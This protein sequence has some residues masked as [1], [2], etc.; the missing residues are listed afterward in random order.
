MN[1][2][3][4][5]SSKYGS[6]NSGIGLSEWQRRAQK[7]AIGSVSGYSADRSDIESPPAS[8]SSSSSNRGS[9]SKDLATNN[10]K[11]I[12]ARQVEFMAK[13]RKTEENNF[14]AF[15]V[16][17]DLAR[18]GVYSL[19]AMRSRALPRGAVNMSSVK[20]ILVSDKSP[21]P[22]DLQNTDVAK[23]ES[24]SFDYDA[25]SELFKA[26][27]YFYTSN[28]TIPTPSEEAANGL[29][30]S[31]SSSRTNS[32]SEEEE[33][34]ANATSRK[35]ETEGPSTL[36][37]ASSNAYYKHI[38]KSLNCTNTLTLENALF[39]DNPRLIVDSHPCLT[40][41]HGNAA[42]SQLTGL[43]SDKVIGKSIQNIFD[44]SF[45]ADS[46]SVLTRTDAGVFSKPA[47]LK[48]R[49]EDK[50]LEDSANNVQGGAEPAIQDEDEN[51]SNQEVSSFAFTASPIMTNSRIS[52][53]VIDLSRSHTDY[54]YNKATGTSDAVQL[55]AQPL[56]AIG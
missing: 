20:L 46:D 45:M 5:A 22:G 56:N 4:K 54:S 10:L 26:A 36:S 40:I 49:L 9:N 25:Y 14:Q 16:K 13:K 41:I 37:S 15:N 35:V 2:E 29:S 1:A 18:A 30:S 17:N 39:C 24:F 31:V 52:H 44:D 12:R 53:Y 51:E 50:Q 21:Y 6:L 38:T 33:L 32:I 43:A 28:Q 3:A 34:T 11:E 8:L 42:F 27:Q 47:T 19:P 23:E 7:R 48:L 55:R